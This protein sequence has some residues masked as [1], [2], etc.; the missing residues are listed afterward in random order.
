MKKEKWKKERERGGSKSNGGKNS[1]QIR[2]VRER[3]IQRKVK[4]ERWRKNEK[5]EKE[6]HLYQAR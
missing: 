4:K 1:F 3:T 2:V 5:K 6:E